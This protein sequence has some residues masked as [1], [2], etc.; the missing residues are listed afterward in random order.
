M[1]LGKQEMRLSLADWLLLRLILG[2]RVFFSLVSQEG[3]KERG[4]VINRKR[5]R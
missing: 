4:W 2:G 3:V 1:N 5:T